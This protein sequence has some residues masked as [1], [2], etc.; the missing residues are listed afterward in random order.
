M[1]PLE[2]RMGYKFRNGLLLAEALTH[3]SI[4][5]ERKNYPFDNQRLEFLGDAVIQLVVTEHLYRLYPDF[6]EGQMTKLRTRIVSRPALKAHA[7]LMD[8]G[9]YLMMGRGEEASGGRERASTLADAFE[10]VVGA[11]YLDGGFDAA[12]NFV[13]RETLDDFERIAKNPEEVNPKGTLQEILQA[14][15]PCAPA[16]EVVEQTGPDHSKHF[17]SKVIWSGIELGRGEGLS[18]KQAQVAAASDA[19]DQR[20]WLRKDKRSGTAASV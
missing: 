12:R 20:L 3:P 1:N 6:S 11:I 10:S 17:V 2:E 7:V 19:L 15:E 5:L 9:R 8:L 4:S 13:L 14:I 18:K 16:Y